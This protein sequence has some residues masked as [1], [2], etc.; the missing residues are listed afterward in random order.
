[1]WVGDDS[2]VPIRRLCAVV[3]ESTDLVSSTVDLSLAPTLAD[4]PCRDDRLRRGVGVPDGLASTI[5]ALF[6]IGLDLA[7]VRGLVD[8][9]VGTRIDI[10]IGALDD[11]IRSVRSGYF[12]ISME[13]GANPDG[14]RPCR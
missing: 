4:L 13:Q 11:V 10:A 1:M 12:T 2:G 3:L 9:E 14:D 5:N 7:A 8:D 6:A